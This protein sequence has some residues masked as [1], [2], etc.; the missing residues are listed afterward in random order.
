MGAPSD[1]ERD[2]DAPDYTGVAVLLPCFNEG[3][4]IGKVVADFEAALPGAT[5]Y[6]FDNASTDDTADVAKKA[7]ATVVHSPDRGKG[8]VVR[9]MFDVVDAD[10]YLMADGDDTYPASEAPIPGIS[11]Q[12]IVEAIQAESPGV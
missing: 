6:V 2:E 5:I 9:H 7:G 10:T 1:S 4:T 12:T 8:N 3:L 11:G